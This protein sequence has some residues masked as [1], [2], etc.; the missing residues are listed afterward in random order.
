MSL[1]KA[2][3]G[4]PRLEHDRLHAHA[5][6]PGVGAEFLDESLRD[7]C[8]HRL[9]ID[10]AAAPDLLDDRIAEYQSAREGGGLRYLLVDPDNARGDAGEARL[11]QRFLDRV[12]L[13]VAEGHEIEARRV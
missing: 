8:L 10:S 5:H 4:L 2:L 11:E 9:R 1:V 3:S 7:R 12:D 13:V 6:A